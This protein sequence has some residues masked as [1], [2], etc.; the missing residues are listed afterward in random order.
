MGSEISTEDNNF[1]HDCY[2]CS[3]IN[4]LTDVMSK[5]SSINYHA[6]VNFNQCSTEPGKEFKIDLDFNCAGA[7]LCSDNRGSFD[8]NDE[9]KKA[10]THQ[11]FVN[12]LLEIFKRA[13][14]SSVTPRMTAL[15]SG[16]TPVFGCACL[17]ERLKTVGG[18]IMEDG[19]TG[20]FSF[21][22]TIVE[23]LL[24]HPKHV[25]KNF[26]DFGTIILPFVKEFFSCKQLFLNKVQSADVI[27]MDDTLNQEA[28]KNRSAFLQRFRNQNIYA[29]ATT[30]LLGPIGSTFLH[31]AVFNRSLELFKFFLDFQSIHLTEAINSRGLGVLQLLMEYNIN[32]LHFEGFRYFNE[33]RRFSDFSKEKEFRLDCFI[34][35]AS[36]GQLADPSVRNH[37]LHDYKKNILITALNCEILDARLISELL[38]NEVG[39][40][41]WQMSFEKNAPSSNQKTNIL[42]ALLE[43]SKRNYYDEA[44]GNLVQKSNRP[45]EYF[46]KILETAVALPTCTKEAKEFKLGGGLTASQAAAQY[47]YEK[48]AELLKINGFS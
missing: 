11:N 14:A 6:V 32:E 25:N 42:F 18:V 38:V 29:S 19:E 39:G 33:L 16:E 5:I 8:L 17:F 22:G 43:T 12:V 35:I 26:R 45:E 23:F 31:A 48:V 47:G 15:N 1:C 4:T 9:C 20:N 27:I 24:F 36:S 28:E 3:N 21:A 7:L 40:D 34:E 46:C 44:T 30:A 10:N 41:P 13:S 2:M 37:G